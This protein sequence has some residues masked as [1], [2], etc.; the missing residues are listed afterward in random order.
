MP[1]VRWWFELRNVC[2]MCIRK[3][4][5]KLLSLA[6][7]LRINVR[8][9]ISFFTEWS[10][11]SSRSCICWQRNVELSD[12]RDFNS[13]WIVYH[14]AVDLKE[15]QQ[16][17]Y[18]IFRNY[19][20]VTLETATEIWNLRAKQGNNRDLEDSWEMTGAM[21]NMGTLRASWEQWVAKIMKNMQSYSVIG[22]TIRVLGQNF[23]FSQ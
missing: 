13:S 6:S 12:Q 7:S 1:L 5:W 4:L 23:M 19:P 11:W 8:R 9:T 21:W 17:K 10:R 16:L 2:M 3:N 14:R 22:I 20:E 18:S 15:K